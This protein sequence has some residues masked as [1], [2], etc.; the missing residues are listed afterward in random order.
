MQECA[1]KGEETAMTALKEKY[2]KVNGRVAF[3][4]MRLGDK[5]GKEVVDEYVY[6]LAMGIA[7]MVNLF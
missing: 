4:A 3:D 2:G 5:A 1:Q 6:Y 7:N